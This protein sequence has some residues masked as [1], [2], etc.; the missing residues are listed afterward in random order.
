M[1]VGHVVAHAEPVVRSRRFRLVKCGA[2]QLPPGGT[3]PRVAG[4][5]PVGRASAPGWRQAPDDPVPA[6]GPREGRRSARIAVAQKQYDG[7]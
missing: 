2:L 1:W 6:A 4:C 7:E 3:P 5:L